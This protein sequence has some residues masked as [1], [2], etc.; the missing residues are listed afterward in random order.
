MYFIYLY[1]VF[2]FYLFVHCICILCNMGSQLPQFIE[3]PFSPLRLISGSYHFII[4]IYMWSVIP[5]PRPFYPLKASLFLFD[6]RGDRLFLCNRHHAGLSVLSPDPAYSDHPA[7]QILV[8]W[9]QWV[10]SEYYPFY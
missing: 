4:S 5:L 2:V 6:A 7:L 10:F 1:V 9:D 8:S 3:S